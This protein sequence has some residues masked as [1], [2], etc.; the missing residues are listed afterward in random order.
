MTRVSAGGR[1]GQR[2]RTR[3]KVVREMGSWAWRK[4]CAAGP[5]KVQ[6]PE[7]RLRPW[8]W[9]E[10]SPAPRDA[11][12]IIEGGPHLPFDHLD[13]WPGNATSA[14]ARCRRDSS[15]HLGHVADGVCPRGPDSAV[16]PP[17]SGGPEDPVHKHRLPAIGAPLGGSLTSAASP[18]RTKNDVRPKPPLQAPCALHN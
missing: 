8:I 2:S 10:G 3:F 7:A 6:M 4:R 14:C 1:Q 17:G 18:L 12:D 16:A 5:L 15:V 13:H 9:D 11:M